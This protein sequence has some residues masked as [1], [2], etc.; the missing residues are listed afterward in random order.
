[1]SKLHSFAVCAYG[2]SP[3]LRECLNSL[4][5]Q[6]YQD[7]DV[8]IS[9]S[10]PS[11]WLSDI[12]AEYGLRVYV[13]EGE[14][15]IGEDWNYAVSKATTPY[16][17]IAHQDDVYDEHYAASAVA[18]LENSPDSLIYFSDYGEVRGNDYVEKNR[19]LSIK[20]ML[21]TPLK[22]RSLQSKRWAKRA[23][24]RFGSAICCPAVTLNLRNCPVPPFLTGLKSNLDWA[25]WEAFSR[26]KGSF[27]YDS[28]SILMYHRI[29]SESTTTKLIVNH[30]RRGEDIQV[31]S[32]FWPKPVAKLIELLY[33]RGE[34]S[35][36]L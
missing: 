10:T 12:A 6:S 4:R 16:V 26:L 2:Q 19:L 23:A 11:E 14:S 30:Q 9:T 17:T 35:N 21:L 29:H 8:Y 1:M 24:L 5:E 7:S 32:L 34:K 3:Y 25:T 28:K 13:N 22:S 20:R 27:V 33:A 15:G 31:L 36:E 18:C